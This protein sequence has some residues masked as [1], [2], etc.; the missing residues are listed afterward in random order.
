MDGSGFSIGYHAGVLKSLTTS[1]IHLRPIRYIPKPG[2][3]ID[4]RV[5]STPKSNLV[6]IMR[7][8]S[9]HWEYESEWRLIVELDLTI[10]T[11]KGTATVNR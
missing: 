7:C 1:G 11:A 3:V 5:L 2:V 6:Q 10:G 4:Y 8:K 9:D